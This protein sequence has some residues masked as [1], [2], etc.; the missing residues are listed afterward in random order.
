M[1]ILP[2]PVIS[3]IQILHLNEYNLMFDI[4]WHGNWEHLRSGIRL[5]E[6]RIIWCGIRKFDVYR[7]VLVVSLAMF[8]TYS[9]R[10]TETV[11][12]TEVVPLV[13]SWDKSQRA[14]VRNDSYRCPTQNSL[15]YHVIIQIEFKP[16]SRFEKF[17][18]GCLWNKTSVC[19]NIR[20]DVEKPDWSFS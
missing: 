8:W 11:Y 14:A 6:K 10:Q 20:L 17:N 13:F 7:T 5:N 1:I 19:Y 2:L 15:L 18:L 4:M 16:T 9:K 3:F 12:V